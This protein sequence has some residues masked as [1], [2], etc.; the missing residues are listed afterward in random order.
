MR[1]NSSHGD[2]VEELGPSVDFIRARAGS[3]LN[4]VGMFEPSIYLFEVN[5]LDTWIVYVS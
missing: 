5:R 4:W 1:K 2:Q 3:W